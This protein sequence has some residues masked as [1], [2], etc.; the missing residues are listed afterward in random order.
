MHLDASEK[1][2]S[3]SLFRE[4]R[5][6]RVAPPEESASWGGAWPCSQR[7]CRIHT[8]HRTHA[9]TRTRNSNYMCSEQQ[10][11]NSQLEAGTRYPPPRGV[12]GGRDACV[13]RNSNSRYHPS[14]FV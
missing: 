3:E 8:E 4:T 11:V 7:A 12:D 9:R 13:T 14:C 10:R 1:R 5:T 6:P 2:A